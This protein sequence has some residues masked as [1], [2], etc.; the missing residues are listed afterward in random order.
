MASEVHSRINPQAKIIWGAQIDPALHH[1][2][3]VIL[4]VTGVKSK[5]IIGHSTG[6]RVESSFGIDFIR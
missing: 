5:Q 1:T 2:V 6:K 4:V 3:R